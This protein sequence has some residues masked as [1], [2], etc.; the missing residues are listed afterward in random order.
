MS[1]L[2]ML[3]V[4]N[5]DLLVKGEEP[6]AFESD[7]R[8][9]ICGACSLVINGVPHGPDRGTTACQLHMRRFNDGDTISIEPWRAKAF[10][11]IRDLVVDRAAFD[12]I[13][14][15]G[16]FVSVNTGAAQ[17]ANTLPIAKQKADAAFDAA[18]C[19]GC[20]ACVAACKNA[21]AMLFVGARVSQFKNLP[22]GQPERKKRAMAM[23]L[24]MDEEGFGSCTN[25]LECEAVCPK[26]ISTRVIAELNQEVLCA[27][28]SIR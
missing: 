18:A 14:Q 13:Q 20:G 12:R 15:A 10:P 16:G 6:I 26:E 1:F 4:V 17:D 3:D 9:G 11:L 24:R 22:Q 8:E 19:I 28:L 5:E 27:Q 2:E 21:S 7:C 23:M 25:T